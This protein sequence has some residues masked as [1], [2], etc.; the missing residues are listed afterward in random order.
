MKDDTKKDS[1]IDDSV[2]IEELSKVKTM[3]L[4]ELLE[5]VKALAAQL[6]EETTELPAPKN[7][8]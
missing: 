8:E 1:I 7:D 6:G 5:R 4:D 2:I 3:S